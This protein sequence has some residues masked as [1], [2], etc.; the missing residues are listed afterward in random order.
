M[1]W[2]SRAARAAF[3]AYRADTGERL[4]AAPVRTGVVAAPMTYA[5]DGERYV[6]VVVGWG[7]GLPRRQARGADGGFREPQPAAWCTRWMAGGSCPG[8]SR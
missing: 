4:W 3:V 5:V 1:S 2:C 8:P 7:G 6:A